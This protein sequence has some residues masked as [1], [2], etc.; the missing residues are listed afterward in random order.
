V[1]VDEL[2]ARLG[3][4]PLTEPGRREPGL[5]GQLLSFGVIGALSTIAYA[6]LYLLLVHLMPAQAANF[7]ALLITAIAN[8]AANRRFTFGVRGRARVATHHAQ[9]LVVFGLAWL[10]TAGSLAALN[11]WAP[12]ASAWVEVAVLTAANIVATLLRF[13][14]LR[15]WVFRRRSAQNTHF[16]Y[17]PRQ[18]IPLPSTPTVDQKASRR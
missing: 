2:Y 9:A 13:V 17:Q 8:T 3:R 6:L 7:G 5:L 1:P 14:L 16:S 12:G 15:G 4:R 11:T 10:I 18:T